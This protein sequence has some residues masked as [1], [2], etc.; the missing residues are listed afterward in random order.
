[1]IIIKSQ[2]SVGPT[3][4]VTVWP[5]VRRGGV[6]PEQGGISDHRRMPAAGDV[7][8]R[9]LGGEFCLLGLRN[10]AVKEVADVPGVS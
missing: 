7:V 5:L 1:M 4:P 10:L 9:Q 3:V 2:V 8:E 6:R